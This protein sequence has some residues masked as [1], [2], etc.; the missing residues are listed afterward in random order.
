MLPRNLQDRYSDLQVLVD[1]EIAV[2]GRAKL[3]AI[4]DKKADGPFPLDVLSPLVPADS[5]R[6]GSKFEVA[7]VTAVIISTVGL[8]V[9]IGT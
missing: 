8:V 1:L 7:Q 6:K 4:L 5:P 2:D 9:D 3:E